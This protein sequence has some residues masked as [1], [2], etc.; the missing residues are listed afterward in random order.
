M[1]RVKEQGSGFFSLHIEKK[2]LISFA[3]CSLIRNFAPAK[4]KK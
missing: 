1:D 3:M 2:M 4:L